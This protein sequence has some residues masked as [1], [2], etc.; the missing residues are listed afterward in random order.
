ML[1]VLWADRRAGTRKIIGIVI[2]KTDVKGFP[3]RKMIIENPLIQIKDLERE[4][5][6][7]PAT[8]R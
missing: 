6:F 7:S 8:P 4:E 3:D 1:D 2:G 5:K